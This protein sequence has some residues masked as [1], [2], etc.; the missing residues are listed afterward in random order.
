MTIGAQAESRVE[1]KKLVVG[2]DIAKAS[3]V[4]VVRTD[5]GASRPLKFQANREGFEK[6]LTWLEEHRQR[7]GATRTIAGLEPT[8]HY[9]LTVAKFLTERGTEVAFVN[10]LHTKRMKE[11]EDNSPDKS[12]PK[13]ATIVAELVFTGKTLEQA[14]CTGVF[15][16]LRE[17][18]RLRH[19]R[20]VERGACENRVHRILDVLFPELLGVLPGPSTPS[21]QALLRVAVTPA[22][23]LR[24]GKR[25]LTRILRN[26]SRGQLEESKA[27]AVLQAAERSVGIEDAA[28]VLR[29]EL[30]Q[31]LARWKELTKQIR[32]IEERQRKALEKVPYADKLLRV[33]GLG[34]VTVARVL[35]EA[36]DLK[37]YRNGRALM[38]MA[39]L[40]LYSFKSGK[41]QRAPVR[42][43][44]RGR[45][46]LRHALY[47]AVL[48]MTREDRPLSEFYDRLTED[49]GVNKVKALVAASRKLLRALFAVVRDNVEFNES[50]LEPKPAKVA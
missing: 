43:T 40:N 11:I 22:E 28:D 17:L 36:G 20:V 23:I 9:W 5:A 47:M 42:I 26:A 19:C 44:K 31:A 37:A 21:T 8:G 39:G 32:E 35:G 2:L 6:L 14:P 13:D 50:L 12:D 27:E 46:M 25:K 24:L 1:G 3:H 48:G 18:G 34:P 45:P 49:N 30:K 38:K 41:K 4:A 15:A 29:L 33:P 10:P 7:E 16:E